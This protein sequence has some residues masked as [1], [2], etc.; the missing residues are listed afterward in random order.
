[1]AHLVA[2]GCVREG[3][4]ITG[5]VRAH[6]ANRVDLASAV[7]VAIAVVSAGRLAIVTA[8]LAWILRASR[9]VHALTRRTSQCAASAGAFAA[10]FATDAVHAVPGLALV[11]AFARL[12]TLPLSAASAGRAV[13]DVIEYAGMPVVAVL[14]ALASCGA[15]PGHTKEW[16]TIN[17]FGRQAGPLAIADWGRIAQGRTGARAGSAGGGFGGPAFARPGPIAITGRIACRRGLRGAHLLR[18]HLPS[19]NQSTPPEEA[20]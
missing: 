7:A 20:R 19:G 13:L 11:R 12:A 9:D 8:G 15:V 10:A 18:I 6:G 2:G 14:V 3:A 16:R 1:L 4:L 5:R 17:Q